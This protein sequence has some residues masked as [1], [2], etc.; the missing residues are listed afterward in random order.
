LSGPV[1]SGHRPGDA[2]TEEDVD[3]VRASDVADRRVGAVILNGGDLARESVWNIPK[4]KYHALF[5]LLSLLFS[6]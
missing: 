5:V 6:H 1:D 2:D 3:G 4:Q